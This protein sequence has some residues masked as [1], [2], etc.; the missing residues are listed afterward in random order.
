[1]TNAVK[2]RNLI[3]D[4]KIVHVVQGKQYINNKEI[5]VSDIYRP[6]LELTGYFDF[7]PRQR[8]QLLGRTEISYAARL[9]HD[10]LV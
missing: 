9:D 6:G 1:M 10:S 8:I 7:Y 4:N 5:V 3:R 2:L